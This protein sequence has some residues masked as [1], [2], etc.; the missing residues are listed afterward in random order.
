MPMR[1]ANRTV[2]VTGAAQGVGLACAAV[3][4]EEGASVVLADIHED[5][6]AT[7]L[8][9]IPREYSKRAVPVVCDVGNGRQVDALVSHAIDHF[10]SLD[11]F[12]CAAAI[13]HRSPFLDVNQDDFDAVIRTNLKGT[14]LCVQAA[15]RAM[16]ELRDR[17][18]DILGSIVTISNDDSF[19]ALPHIVP[20]VMAAGGVDRM[21]QTLARSLAS[22]QVRI[23]SIAAGL[24]DTPLL[25][26]ATGTGKTAINTGLARNA[27]GRTIDPDEIAKIAAF[28]ASA[29]A[30]AMTGQTV[31]TGAD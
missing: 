9:G 18:K 2:I 6:L 16:L 26:K 8:D 24:V 7:V 13:M 12:V 20:H 11:S 5:N 31:G 27:Q 10:G 23:N 3:F 29:D 21:V 17:G 1:F 30:S 19:A 25:Q 4:L 15:A 28:L 14:F 22:Y